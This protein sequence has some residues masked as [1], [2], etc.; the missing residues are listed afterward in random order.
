MAIA[1]NLVVGMSAD[2][3]NF[4]KDMKKSAESLSIVTR[5]VSK[6]S[7]A[8]AGFAGGLAFAGVEAGIGLITAGMHSAVEGIL[9]ASAAAS[10]LNETISK[11]DAIL[12]DASEGVKRFAD[13]Y[14]AQFG[15]V[16]KETLEA[17]SAFGGLGKGLGK[18]SGQ[19]LT[20]FSI[21]FTK[22]AY[23]LSSFANISM[24]EATAA[25]QTGLTGEMSDTLKKLGVI[26]LEDT[27]KA[28]AFSN[29]IAKAGTA[30]TESQK[31]AARS[32]LIMKG[33][34]DAQG[35]LARTASGAAN[36]T[37]SAFGRL[38]NIGSD[39][40]MAIQPITDQI[41][42]LTNTALKQLGDE[43]V[44]NREAINEWAGKAAADGGA[45]YAAF[46]IAGKGLGKILDAM[47]L[48][49]L[50]WQA[51]KSF[52]LDTLTKMTA[53]FL[54]FFQAWERGAASFTGNKAFLGSMVSL[55][56][57]E[58]LEKLEA[59]ANEAS[60]A[61]RET[62]MGPAPSERIAT[63]FEELKTKAQ[64]SSKAV[65]DTGKA[66][67][68]VATETPVFANKLSEITE[69]L[70]QQIETF[71]MTS[72]QAAIYKV[73]IMGATDAD[74]KLVTSLAAQHKALETNKSAYEETRT[75]LEKY[76]AKIA[77][78]IESFNAGAMSE[79]TFN[80][81]FG[82]AKLDY[83]GGSKA[84]T[85]AGATDFNSAEAR[86]TLLNYANTDTSNPIKDVAKSSQRQEAIQT[87]IANGID[88]MAAK[89]GD[90]FDKDEVFIQ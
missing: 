78:L 11:T 14:A 86:S 33:L 65:A 6:A 17:A 13:E 31:V 45:V 34:A 57:I 58:Q 67:K 80:R 47:Q 63:F 37:R 19:P 50:S 5:E 8:V 75:P 10:D 85:Y 44:R 27:V 7:A 25:L 61:M 3:A 21:R 28:Y 76:Q 16:K 88:K 84:N 18:L 70:K 68:E 81:G 15:A 66:L 40:G 82:A 36:Q 43:V 79:Q 71:G 60:A 56:D 83:E 12:G 74:L 55:E 29:G 54:Q 26:L 32:G 72:D 38:A 51:T 87:R 39:F 24:P 77:D 64:A 1:G 35:D 22:L 4:V 41:L 30:L 69:S 48:F 53:G 62:F 42:T 73:R 49:K 2:V 9:K 20:D 52:A 46:E 89:L 59:A 90:R 23:D